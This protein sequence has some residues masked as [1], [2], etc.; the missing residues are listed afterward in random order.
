M[1]EMCPIEPPFNSEFGCGWQSRDTIK[2]V[3]M[4]S[5][6]KFFSHGWL[7]PNVIAYFDTGLFYST[8]T[9]QISKCIGIPTNGYLDYGGGKLRY[10]RVTDVYFWMDL[11]V[12]C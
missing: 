4:L 11:F 1:E 3:S 2:I 5:W 6:I 10:I 7:N 8:L 9:Y 12:L